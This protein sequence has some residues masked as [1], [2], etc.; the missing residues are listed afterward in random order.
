MDPRMFDGLF[1]GLLLIGALIGLGLA[2]LI[3]FLV[4]LF[5]HIDINWVS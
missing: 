4:W 1:T 5:S 2:G 3:W